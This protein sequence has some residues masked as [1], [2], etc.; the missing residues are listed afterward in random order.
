MASVESALRAA[1]TDLNA[2][3]TR[4]APSAALPSP[5][6]RYPVYQ[7]PDFAP[8]ARRQ[9]PGWGKPTDF[10]ALR[11]AAGSQAPAFHA[12]AVLAATGDARE[13]ALAAHGVSIWL[14]PS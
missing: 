6:G 8:D 10:P 13:A 11:R 4:R 9:G 5:R 14:P 1:A 12:R 7:G 2:A 3:G